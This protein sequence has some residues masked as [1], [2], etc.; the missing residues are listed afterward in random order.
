MITILVCFVCFIIWAGFMMA[1]IGLHNDVMRS[2]N[3]NDF[4]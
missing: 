1:L 3:N 4:K 2:E